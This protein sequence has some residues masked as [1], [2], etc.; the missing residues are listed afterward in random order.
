MTVWIVGAG[1]QLARHLRGADRLPAARLQAATQGG[2]TLTA[3]HAPLDATR[4][5]NKA[6]RLQSCRL[7]RKVCE[8]EMNMC[9]RLRKVIATVALTGTSP[10]VI[11]HQRAGK[12]VKP[13]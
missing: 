5:Q 12:L 2:V 9:W 8:D 4:A 6:Q 3:H 10:L 13:R 1:L 7:L 11:H